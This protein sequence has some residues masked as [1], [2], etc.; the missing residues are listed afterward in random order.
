VV[1]VMAAAVG[2]KDLVMTV[3][4]FGQLLP[5]NNNKE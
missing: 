2:G 3:G 5:G 1:V 4:Y